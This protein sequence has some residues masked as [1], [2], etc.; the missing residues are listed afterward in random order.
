LKPI[1]R[2]SQQTGSNQKIVASL[3]VHEEAF[4]KCS[5]GNSFFGGDHVSYLHIALG[6]YFDWIGATENLAD[7][8]LL[9][10]EKSAL[11]G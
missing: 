4:E 10:K 1:T 5:K 11:F 9:E 8:R 6:S 7:V 3:P 2:P